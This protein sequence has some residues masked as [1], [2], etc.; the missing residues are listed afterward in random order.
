MNTSSPR[1][2]YGKLDEEVNTLT[3]I[4]FVAVAILSFC[5]VALK[6]ASDLDFNLSQLFSDCVT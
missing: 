4:L 3:K 5:M 2:K 6:G 1:S